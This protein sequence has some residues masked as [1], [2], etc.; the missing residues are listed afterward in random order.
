MSCLMMEDMHAE[1]CSDT[2][3]DD[4]NT[5]QRSLADAPLPVPC[6]LLIDSVQNERKEIDREQIDNQY[7]LH[8]NPS[9]VASVPSPVH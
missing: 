2:A 5:D 7:S 1:V 4:C 3:P 8:Q 9:E 6:P